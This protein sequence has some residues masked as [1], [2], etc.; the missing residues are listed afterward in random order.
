MTFLPNL[1]PVC[2]SSERPSIVASLYNRV[3]GRYKE[4]SRMSYSVFRLQVV[5]PHCRSLFEGGFASLGIVLN[6]EE[7]RRL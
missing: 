2:P 1:P 7:G 4:V 3:C 5:T 6:E